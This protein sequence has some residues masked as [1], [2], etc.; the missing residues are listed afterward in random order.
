VNMVRKERRKGKEEHPKDVAISF[1]PNQQS[2]SV[3]HIFSLNYITS[4]VTTL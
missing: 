2:P 1:V 4:V 3:L